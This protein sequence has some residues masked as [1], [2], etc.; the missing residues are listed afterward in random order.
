L[1]DNIRMDL[2]EVGWGDAAWI[3]VGQNNYKWRALVNS[4][5][6]LRVLCNAR[7]LSSGLT[8][9]STSSS[10]QLHIVSYLSMNL[11]YDLE[12]DTV[13][14]RTRFLSH[15]TW[16]CIVRWNSTDVSKEIFATILRFQ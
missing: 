15:G 13:K 16:R 6:N 2:E 1:V 9:R 3:C 14:P 7:K 5:V 11:Y 12:C 10:A 8:T 4:V